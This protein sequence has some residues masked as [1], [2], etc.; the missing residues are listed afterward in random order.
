[1]RE[2]FNLNDRFF[3]HNATSSKYHA[4]N[5]LHRESPIYSPLLQDNAPGGELIARCRLGLAPAN[6][7]ATTI[8][9]ATKGREAGD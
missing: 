2:V 9:A 3:H 4:R 6:R 7:G 5:E 1:M 8:C